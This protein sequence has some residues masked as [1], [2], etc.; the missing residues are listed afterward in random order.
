MSLLR[1]LPEVAVRRPLLQRE[2][3]IL[4][5]AAFVAVVFL[6][7]NGVPAL[8]DVFR[9]RNLQIEN[10]RA[11]IDREQRLIDGADDW[12]QRRA[13][14]EQRLSDIESSLF[15]AG[16]A[17]LL[18]AAIQRQ[19]REIGSENGLIITS[20]SLADSN[21]SA[22]WL[23]VEQTMSFA[24]GDQNSMLRFLNALKQSEPFLGV[25]SLDLRRN[26][27]QYIGEITVVGFS[28]LTTSTQSEE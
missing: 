10:L 24:L 17:A 11:D 19:A 20:V 23:M 9:S 8:L 18:A 13:D 6:L 5:L 28:R 22:D 25:S 3:R 26:R 14:A 21:I 2:K 16:S 7:T 12:A 4:G 27:N 15:T 1:K